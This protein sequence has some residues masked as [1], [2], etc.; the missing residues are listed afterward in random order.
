MMVKTSRGHWWLLKVRATIR[1]PDWFSICFLIMTGWAPFNALAHADSG[2]MNFSA[3]NGTV[4][5]L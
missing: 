5:E 4:R 3:S 2:S 1:C